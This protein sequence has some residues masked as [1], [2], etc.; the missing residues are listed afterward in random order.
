M[1]VKFR[2]FRG[3]FSSWDKL[4]TQAAEFATEV[5]KENVINISHSQDNWEGVV[6]VW[7]WSDK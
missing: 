4:F 6:T 2:I 7:Y 1:K 3:P 5:R